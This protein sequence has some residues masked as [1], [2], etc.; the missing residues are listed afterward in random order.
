[1]RTAAMQDSAVDDMMFDL[2]KLIAY[3]SAPA[4]L[5]ARRLPDRH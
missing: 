1:M 4:L 3:A 2:L 5:P